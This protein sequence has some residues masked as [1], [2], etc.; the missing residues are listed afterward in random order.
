MGA[1]EKSGKAKEKS[2]KAKEKSGKAKGAI[3]VKKRGI[4]QRKQDKQVLLNIRSLIAF[5]T[6]AA[7]KAE[8]LKES[9]KTSFR[10]SSVI[11]LIKLL[12]RE[13]KKKNIVLRYIG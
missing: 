5:A 2:G 7:D 11:L 3:K 4:A 10:S 9:C 13:S 12:A 1:K 6:A 8:D